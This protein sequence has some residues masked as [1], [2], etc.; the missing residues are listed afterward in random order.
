MQNGQ[1]KKNEASSLIF[2]VALDGICSNEFI[3]GLRKLHELQGVFVDKG[4]IPAT[5]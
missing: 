2:F 1:C 5:A 3:E 4:L